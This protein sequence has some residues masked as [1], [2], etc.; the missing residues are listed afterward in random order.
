MC[1]KT[2]SLDEVDGEKDDWV[3]QI[4]KECKKKNENKDK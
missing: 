4:C 1:G 3:N 2:L